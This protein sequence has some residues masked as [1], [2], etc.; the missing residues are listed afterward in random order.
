M[1]MPQTRVISI[2]GTSASIVINLQS[3]D[4]TWMGAVSRLGKALE[5][6]V[7]QSGEFDGDAEVRARRFMAAR[8][9]FSEG[10]FEGASEI[11]EGMLADEPAFAPG[12]E[13]LVKSEVG[14]GDA[15]N[16][17]AAIEDWNEAGGPGAPDESSVDE[18]EDAVAADGMRGYWAWT[19][20][21]LEEQASLGAPVSAVERATAHAALGHKEEALAYLAEGL[22]S[23][24]R[25]LLTLQADPVWDSFRRLPEFQAIAREARAM[26]FAPTRRRPGG[27]N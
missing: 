18:L 3:M 15:E 4:S 13:M 11:L 27:G 25:Q 19:L 14:T 22:R 8:R 10:Q 23:G 6:R 1:D 12:W 5:M 17:V 21:R 26:R 20:D 7:I 2:P 9:L 24:D 16:V